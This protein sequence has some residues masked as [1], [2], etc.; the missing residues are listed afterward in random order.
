MPFL[1]DDEVRDLVS[2]A[3][4]KAIGDRKEERQAANRQAVKE[5]IEANADDVYDLSCRAE[6]GFS[7]ACAQSR[8]N[9]IERQKMKAQRELRANPHCIDTEVALRSFRRDYS[10]VPSNELDA[11]IREFSA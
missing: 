6:S 3:V 2:R 8:S 10:A 5:L 11:I 1:T 9:L 7:K 4:S